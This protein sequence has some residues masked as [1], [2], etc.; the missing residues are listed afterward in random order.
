M[1]SNLFR[2]RAVGKHLAKVQ[3]ALVALVLV[4]SSFPTGARATVD[5][6]GNPSLSGSCGLDIALVMDTSTSI[7]NTELG[8]MRTAL[9]GFVDALT[10]TPSQFAL[11]RF[12][13]DAAT[14]QT[15]TADADAV[16]TAIDATDGSGATNWEAG[17]TEAASNFD[18]RPSKQNVVI[19]ASD[20]NPTRTI[21]NTSTTEEVAVDAAVGVANGIKNGSLTGGN[22]TRIITIGI[23]GGQG[24]AQ[25]LDS[26]NLIAISSADA[27]YETANFSDLGSVLQSVADDLCG[28][29]INVTKVID[30]DGNLD[31]T[32]DQA[33]AEGWTFTVGNSQQVTD[34][35]GSASFPVTAGTYAIAE[36]GTEGYQFVD[37]A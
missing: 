27:Y 11:V 18:P 22:P 37:A 3:A 1:Y 10:G 15:F 34:Q 33:P 2:M 28:G 4:A 6:S 32:D 21:A 26:A 8:Q 7:D 13:D 24:Q 19:F 9:K 31:T 20:G 12:D 14:T 36:T 5:P 23:G 30:Q 35:T 25:V 16:K 29:T 17:L